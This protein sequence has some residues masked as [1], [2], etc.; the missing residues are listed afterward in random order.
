MSR[1]HMIIEPHCYGCFGMEH[2]WSSK[3]I[4]IILSFTHLLKRRAVCHKLRVRKP[5]LCMLLLK[6]IRKQTQNLPLAFIENMQLPKNDNFMIQIHAS[7]INWSMLRQEKVLV[8]PQWCQLP[9]DKR[10]LSFP[11]AELQLTYVNLP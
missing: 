11:N 5:P 4:S 8:M 3:F 10:N 1:D 2:H 6:A 7:F 9:T